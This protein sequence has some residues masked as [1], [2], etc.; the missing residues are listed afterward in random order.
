MKVKLH[1]LDMLQ[2]LKISNILYASLFGLPI[3]FDE[4]RKLDNSG[5]AKERQKFLFVN[6][7]KIRLVMHAYV[8]RELY[9]YI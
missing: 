4:L 2:L 5:I 8:H 1:T 7:R 6:F 9:S 3:T